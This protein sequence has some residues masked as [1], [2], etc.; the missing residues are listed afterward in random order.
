VEAW[1]QAERT[2]GATPF[3][4]VETDANGSFTLRLP[5]G[6]YWLMARDLGAVAGPRRIAEF[7]GNP[8]RVAA[9]GSVRPGDAVLAPAGGAAAI[10]TGTGVRGRVVLEGLPVAEAAVMVYPPGRERLAGPGYAA[11]VRTLPDGSFEVDLEPG[12]YLIA[13]RLRRGGSP[14]GSL[15]EGDASATAEG[16]IDVAAGAYLDLGEIALHPVDRERLDAERARGFQ[17][18][19]G[20]VLEGRV[21][22][23]QG[24]PRAGMFVFVY[25]DEGMIGRPAAA[26]ETGG[27]GSFL[28]ALPGGGRYFVG[29]RSGRGGPRRPGEWSGTLT[30]AGVEGLVVPEGRRVRGVT[31]T[32]SQEW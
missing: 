6:S 4:A 10:A 26:A 24:K 19:A 16:G 13:V 7:P 3:A 12:S 8:A 25:M 32:V 22:D 14:M 18:S 27:D 29:A 23:R 21:V 2:A 30:A 1:L 31:V 15:R 5:A 17:P 9:G 11:L 28:V 20:T